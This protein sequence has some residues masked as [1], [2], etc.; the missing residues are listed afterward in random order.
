MGNCANKEAA[1]SAQN[2]DQTYK[3]GHNEDGALETEFETVIPRASSDDNLKF[4]A[5]N[6]KGS[7][8]KPVM[9]LEHFS[10]PFEN[11]VFADGGS[12]TIAYSGVIRVG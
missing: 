3:Y 5:P 2:I 9:Q 4:I 7:S 6:G 12:T 8:V 1:S 11:L 10:F